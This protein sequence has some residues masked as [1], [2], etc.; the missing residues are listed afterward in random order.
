MPDSNRRLGCRRADHPQIGR[1]EL[2]QAGG[3]SLLGTG[4]G[5]LLRLEAMA[6]GAGLPARAKSVVFIFQSG[7]PSQHE[8]FDPKP[9]ASDKVRGEYGV[10]ATKNP[11]LTICE[12][13]PKLAQRADRFSI[14]RT[15]Y[16]PADRQFRNEHSAAMYMVNTGVCALP[17]G[18]N[19]NS[20]AIQKPRPLEWP[21][22]GSMLAYALPPQGERRL[23]PVIEIPRASGNVGDVGIPGTGPG[24][25]GPR[26]SRWRVNLAPVCRAPDAA[27]SCPNCFSH[28]QPDDPERQPGKLPKSWYDNSSCRNPDF[29]L[30]DL[31][32]SQ[33]AVIERVV[34]RAELLQSL[35]GVRR[36][37]DS[38]SGIR[39]YDVFQRQALDLI[40][41]QRGRNNPFDITQETAATRDQYG[42]EE[43][44]QAF[45]VARR[46]V[47]AGVRM[48]QVNLRGWDTHQNAFRDLKGKL[49]PSLDHC[50]SGFLDD[51]HNRGL[52]DETL[53]V[54]CG[55][56]G[57]TPIISPI[58]AGGLNAAG[59]PFTPGRHHWGDVFPCFFAGAGIRPGLTIGKTDRQGGVPNSEGYTPADLAATI[60][61]QLGIGPDREFHDTDGRPFRIYQGTP[62]APLL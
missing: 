19:T 16:H 44:G 33:G 17:P 37:L 43:W 5:D 51:L 48:V 10:I 47:E 2:L 53:I 57:R 12:H 55:E 49:L 58:A 22:I 25:V 39:R 59:V 46:L 21:S 28:D 32:T 50:L 24:M 14:V 35:D 31:G 29:A 40:V 11:D 27:G 60:F 30:P 61:S 45:L 13:L 52:L 56:M 20:I 38:H 41:S 7:G 42:R 23:P 8:T 54:M 4:L 62:I 34:H 3:L 18:E 15:M 9:E 1:R 36:D 6:A 26:F